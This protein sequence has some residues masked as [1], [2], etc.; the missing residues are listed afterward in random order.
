MTGNNLAYAFQSVQ[1]RNPDV[2]AMPFPDALLL[3]TIARG[4]LF[5][6]SDGV[7]TYVNRYASEAL[8]VWPEPVIG[9]RVDML[10]LSTP[11]YKVL[12]EQ[13]HGVPL[14]MVIKGRVIAAQSTRPPARGCWPT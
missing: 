13:C 10:S 1:Q 6:N 7:L 12:S 9:K 2:P 4:V 14:E 3:D 5:V 11:L 8:H